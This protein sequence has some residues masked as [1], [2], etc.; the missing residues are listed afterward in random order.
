M[1]KK[2]NDLIG[3]ILLIGLGA[4]ALIGQFVDFTET[5]GLFVLHIIAAAFLAAGVLTRHAGFIIP[6]GED[7]PGHRSPTILRA[8]PVEP[9]ED[10]G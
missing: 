4:L 8:K 9:R 1:N 6:G 10:G 3:G 2:R 5:M 7:R